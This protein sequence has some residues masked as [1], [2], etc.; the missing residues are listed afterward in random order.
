MQYVKKPI[1]INAFHMLTGERVPDWLLSL[2]Q[3]GPGQKMKPVAHG[4]HRV[5]TDHGEVDVY[6][7]DWILQGPSGEIYPITDAKFVETYE[8][9]PEPLVKDEHFSYAT[10][11]VHGYVPDLSLIGSVWAHSGN[12]K[13][14]RIEGFAWMGATDEWGYVHRSETGPLCCR[15]MSHLTGKRANGEPRYERM[16]GPAGIFV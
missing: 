5:I 6:N 2:M 14:Y 16:G 1:P 10:H 4:L 12:Q 13:L 3:P 15:P 9:A 7:G 8:P 11:D